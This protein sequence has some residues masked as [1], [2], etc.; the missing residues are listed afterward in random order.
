MSSKVETRVDRV[1][2]SGHFSLPAKLCFVMTLSLIY[3]L[4]IAIV[5]LLNTVTWAT[6]DEHFFHA[7]ALH[8]MVKG[9]NVFFAVAAL[10]TI[11]RMSYV[12]GDH[13]LSIA[14]L[15]VRAHY[16]FI[17]LIFSFAIIWIV[18]I[19][20]MLCVH[21]LYKYNAPSYIRKDLALQLFFTFLA[22]NTYVIFVQAIFLLL[23]SIMCTLRSYHTFRY[24]IKLRELRLNPFA[25]PSDAERLYE[26]RSMMASTTKIVGRKPGCGV[27]GIPPGLLL[28]QGKHNPTTRSKLQLLQ[29]ADL[30]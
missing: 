19:L 23:T 9:F 15:R 12:L 10:V 28:A 21:Y 4:I 18:P 5:S 3:F 22:I 14:D 17:L 29:H 8:M 11:I 13:I 6:E 26:A 27:Y 7:K 16:N 25:V 24:L 2:V 30:Y 20:Y 1:R